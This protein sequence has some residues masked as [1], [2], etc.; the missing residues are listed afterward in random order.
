[1]ARYKNFY[2]EVVR[3]MMLAQYNYCDPL[4]IPEL[5]SIKLSFYLNNLEDE[6]DWRIVTSM[7]LLSIIT[8]RV[9]GVTYTGWSVTRGRERKYIFSCNVRLRGEEAYRLLEYLVHVVFPLQ[10]RRTGWPVLKTTGCGAYTTYF[11]DLG[12]F[13]RNNE[14]LI[15]FGGHLVCKIETTSQSEEE[16]MTLLRKMGVPI[17]GYGLTE[18]PEVLDQEYM[19]EEQIKAKLD[20]LEAGERLVWYR[21]VE[22]CKGCK[23]KCEKTNI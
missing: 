14:N 13:Y 21:C 11:K 22:I 7:R 3:P 4:K 18:S 9:P 23:N 20:A 15:E 2:K 16:G 5:K 8:G 17:Y 10:A 19:S 1:M 6:E 12:V